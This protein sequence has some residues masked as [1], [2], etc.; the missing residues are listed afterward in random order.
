MSSENL[1]HGVLCGLTIILLS[2]VRERFHGFF[3]RVLFAALPGGK[4]P[5]RATDGSAGFDC[6]ASTTTRVLP[7]SVA[8]VPLGFVC[9]IPDGYV[10]LLVMRSGVASKGLLAAPGG[11]GVIDSDYRGEVS[12]LVATGE[13]EV[14]VGAGERIAQ[15]VI[16]PCVTRSSTVG[17]P[18][19]L[20][21]TVRGAGGF[22]STGVA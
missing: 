9:G 17:G 22:G 7:Y 3:N 14:T 16:V 10:G 4:V 21:D 18:G 13:Q 11:V 8:K 12:A 15:L 5:K 20:G 6:Y 2:W 1:I 19:E